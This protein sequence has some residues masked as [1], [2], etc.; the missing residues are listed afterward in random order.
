MESKENKM[1]EKQ[2]NK[3][4]NAEMWNKRKA[5]WEAWK[6]AQGKVK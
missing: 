5:R 2:A 6:I 4:K 3:I 1:S